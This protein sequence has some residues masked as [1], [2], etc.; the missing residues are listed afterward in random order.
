ME[1]QHVSMADLAGSMKDAVIE[2]LRERHAEN[3]ETLT[4]LLHAY[5]DKLKRDGYD[6]AL[7]A[8]MPVVEQARRTLG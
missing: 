6:D 1:P 8:S 7:I 3:T 2:A 5:V 4:L